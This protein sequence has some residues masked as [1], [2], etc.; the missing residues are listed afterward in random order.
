LGTGVGPPALEGAAVSGVID[1]APR[2]KEQG[3]VALFVIARS[4]TE[5]QILAVRKEERPQ[6]PFSF[7]IS[8]ADQM[9]QGTAFAG[10]LDIT[11]RLSK[12]GEA[13]PS[14]G[15]LEGVARGVSPPKEGVRILLDTQRP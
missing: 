1:L 9:V 14:K 11:A 7:R 3:G 13:M 15:D 2:F 6:F 5:H 4:A 12:S 8:G 10:P